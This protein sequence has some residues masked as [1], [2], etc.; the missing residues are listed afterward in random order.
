[1]LEG[2]RCTLKVAKIQ[3]P[4]KIAE[5]LDAYQVYARLKGITNIEEDMTKTTSAANTVIPAKR[6]SDRTNNATTIFSI[7]SNAAGSEK[8]LLADSQAPWPAPSSALSI[9][10]SSL[11]YARSRWQSLLRLAQERLQKAGITMAEMAQK[12]KLFKRHRADNPDII[13]WDFEAF[14]IYY[15]INSGRCIVTGRPI[16]GMEA[17]TDRICN[18][19]RY[20]LG[21]VMFLNVGSNMAKRLDPRFQHSRNAEG[22]EYMSYGVD[23]LQ[24]DF[25][26]M[27]DQAEGLSQ[28]WQQVLDAL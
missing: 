2:I 23:L 8:L 11:E 12:W 17:Q 22:K 9:D 24:Q 16:Q 20:T 27:L 21:S 15:G 14:V 10:K 13:G 5:L 7:S 18:N 6:I 26:F 28:F 25:Q 1:M 4:I 19:C 3:G